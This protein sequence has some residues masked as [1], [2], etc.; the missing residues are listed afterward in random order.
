MAQTDTATMQA[1][2]QEATLPSTTTAEENRHASGQRRVNIIWEATQA[3]IALTV[4]IATVYAALQG[5]ESA[6]LGNAFFLVVGFYFGRTN[7]ERVGGVI[8]RR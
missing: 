7:H 3:T 2:S 4:A 1:Q 5:I 8:L 6:A